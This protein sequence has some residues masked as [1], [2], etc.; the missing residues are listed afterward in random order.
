M[1]RHALFRGIPRRARLMHDAAACDE[2][3]AARFW[4]W[5][6][7]AAAARV[8]TV[9]EEVRAAVPSAAVPSAAVAPSEVPRPAAAAALLA[10]RREALAS[11]RVAVQ[12]EAVRS[13]E[14]LPNASKTANA[15]CSAIAAAA[16]DCPREAQPRRPVSRTARWTAAPSKRSAPHAASRAAASRVST[17]T[18]LKSSATRF[19]RSAVPEPF[20]ASSADAGAAACKRPSAV[21]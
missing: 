2:H 20:R 18:G 19:R 9:V 8:G 10:L 15:S 14:P 3:L 13:P 12:Q 6:W 11:A 1:L 5:W 17:A 16:S 7:D 4:S 21:G